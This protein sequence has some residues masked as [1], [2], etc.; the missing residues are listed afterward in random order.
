[1]ILSFQYCKTSRQNDETAEKWMG[2]KI[3]RAAECKCK[4]NDRRLKE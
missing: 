2:K 4:E 3:I 1:M